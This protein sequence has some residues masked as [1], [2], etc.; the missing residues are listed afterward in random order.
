MNRKVL[1]IGNGPSAAVGSYGKLIDQFDGTVVRFNKCVLN[2]D[3]GYRTDVWVTWGEG[4]VWR[5]L[6]QSKTIL[7][8]AAARRQPTADDFHTKYKN[9]EGYERVTDAV[10]HGVHA[11]IN[12]PSAGAT[13]AAHFL[14]EPNVCDVYLHG[15]DH[16]SVSRHHYWDTQD[17]SSGHS[18][19]EESTWFANLIEQGRVQRWTPPTFLN[20]NALEGFLTE[21]KSY[22]VISA[23]TVATAYEDAARLLA[24]SLDKHSVPYKIYPYLSTGDWVKNTMVKA[25]A[26]LAAMKEF[27]DKDIIWLDADCIL[28]EVPDFF[29]SISRDRHDLCCHYHRGN[30]LLTGTIAFC[31]N[32]RTLA[33]VEA[34]AAITVPGWDQKHLQKLLSDY[35][36]IRVLSLPQRY[37]VMRKGTSETPHG[38]IWHKQL[39]RSEKGRIMSHNSATIADTFTLIHD[40]KRWGRNVS[41]SG[42]T[43]HMTSRLREMLPIVFSRLGIS[44]IFDAACGDMVWMSQMDL[45]SISYIGADIVP[46]LIEANRKRYPQRSFYCIDITNDPLP[47]CDLV[48]ARDVLVH[49]GFSDIWRFIR[50]VKA[51]GAKY[52][53][54]TSFP[55]RRANSDIKPGQWRP[56]NF[57]AAPFLFDLPLISINERCPQVG[58]TFVDKS[59]CFWKIEDLPCPL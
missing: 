15:F 13:V 3:V 24:Q 57:E 20:V 26:V 30:E 50:A 18:S 35:P 11:Y 34:W 19:V 4:V 25:K 7:S 9:R 1:L 45:G 54:I 42:S 6:G 55:G 28:L 5:D 10:F 46:S 17:H 52:L 23:F 51:T 56:V 59:I 47:S 48:F 14:T 41:G 38:V 37:I 32:P 33:L 21:S 49:L 2:D 27:P 53:A 39:S 58:G 31:N 44:S 43:L 29:T 16:F 40:T 8:T 12:H 22:I 36:D